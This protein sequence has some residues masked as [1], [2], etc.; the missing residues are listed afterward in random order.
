MKRTG[1]ALSLIAAIAAGAGCSSSSG[2]PNRTDGGQVGAPDVGPDVTSDGAPDL[3]PDVAPD[4]GGSADVP[5]DVPPDRGQEVASPEAGGTDARDGGGDIAC[6]LPIDGPL[7]ST[8]AATFDDPSWQHGICDSPASFRP[9]VREQLC[10]GFQSRSFDYGTHRFICYYDPS[11]LALVGGEFVD[12][13][14]AFCDHTTVHVSAGD[15]P[16][17]SCNNSFGQAVPCGADGGG[18]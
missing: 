10:G 7:P 8:C 9:A 2:L 14:S 15:V 12:D 6:H 11:T 18:Q 13:T 1:I 3:A 5:I 16:A 4:L 17:T